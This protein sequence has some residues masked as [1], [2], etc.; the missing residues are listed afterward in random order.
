MKKKPVHRKYLGP[1]DADLTKSLEGIAMKAKKGL[2]AVCEKDGLRFDNAKEFQKHIDDHK[3]S[4][5]QTPWKIEDSQRYA[6]SGS[7][8][9]SHGDEII[10]SVIVNIEPGDYFQKEILEMASAEELANAAFIV[11]AVNCHEELLDA[12]KAM[13]KQRRECGFVKHES[14]LMADKAI[15]KA[16]GK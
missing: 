12:L 8:D 11:R 3:K 15:A 7:I 14:E 1:L 13:V 16:D 10:A 6:N 4:H 5:T 2:N 9:I